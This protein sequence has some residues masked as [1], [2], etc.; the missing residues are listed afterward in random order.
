MMEGSGF[1]PSAEAGEAAPIW[2]WLDQLEAVQHVQPDHEFR[3]C[4]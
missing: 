2:W 1:A 4:L 3:T